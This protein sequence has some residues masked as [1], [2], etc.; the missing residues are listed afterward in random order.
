[1]KL[2]RDHL[3]R[4]V[5]PTLTA[6]NIDFRNGYGETLVERLSRETSRDSEAGC[7]SW[8]GHKHKQGYGHIK[9]NGRMQL[10]HRL[11]LEAVGVD[12]PRGVEVC[13]RCDNAECVNPSHLFLGTHADNM[14]DMRE[15]GRSAKGEKIGRAALTAAQVVDIRRSRATP[16]ELAARHGITRS[17]VYSVLRRDTWRHVP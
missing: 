14:R 2:V 5:A 13:H 16:L 8:T 6:R 9:W 12:V 3:G 10:T 11:A 7:W 1:M 4:P 17:G 15:K